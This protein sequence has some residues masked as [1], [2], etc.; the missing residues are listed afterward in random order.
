MKKRKK[1]K[2]KKGKW[3]ALGKFKDP[4]KAIEQAEEM[5]KKAPMT[6]LHLVTMNSKSLFWIELFLATIVLEGAWII[7]WLILQYLI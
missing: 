1:D 5:I 2:M 4:K 6:H 7:A 3:V